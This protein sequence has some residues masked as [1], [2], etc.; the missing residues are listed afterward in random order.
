MMG[1]TDF[2]EAGKNAL[3]GVKGEVIGIGHG[4]KT[5]I[6]GSAD[7]AVFME[8]YA[9][10]AEYRNTIDKQAGQIYDFIEKE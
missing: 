3:H 5:I 6:T 2:T 7:L 8:K 4:L 10:K 9:F 1:N